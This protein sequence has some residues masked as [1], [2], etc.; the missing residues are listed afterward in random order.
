[1]LFPHNFVVFVP[2]SVGDL[3]TCQLM[4][5]KKIINKGE[6]F[7]N[8]FESY[9]IYKSPFYVACFKLLPIDDLFK[10]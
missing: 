7:L 2:L 9:I 4:E 10:H 6:I 1:M 8:H 3:S 5:K